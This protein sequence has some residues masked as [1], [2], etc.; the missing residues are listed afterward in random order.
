MQEVYIVSKFSR[1]LGVFSTFTAAERF[2]VEKS[3]EDLDAWEAQKARF[4][5]TSYSQLSPSFQR[6]LTQAP[7]T[8]QHYAANYNIQFWEVR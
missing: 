8:V 5:G 6:L 3:Q 7:R 4:Q 2:V 1:I